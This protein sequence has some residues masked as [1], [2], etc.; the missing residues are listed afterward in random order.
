MNSR[1][2]I[3]YVSQFFILVGLVAGALLLSGFAAIIVWQAMVGGDIMSIEKG[4]LDPANAD[5]VKMVQLVSSAIM[6]LLPAFVFAL[7]VNKRPAKHL[8]LRTKFNWAQV[9]LITVMVFVAFGLSGALGELTTEIPIAEKWEKKFKAWEKLYVDQVM[10]MANMKNIG[11]YLYTL[12]VIAVAPAIF[13][14]LLFRGALQQLMVKWTRVAWLGILITSLLFSAVH[15][16]YYG[17]FART[18]LGMVL[19]YMFYFSKSLWLPIIAHFINNGFAVTAMYYMN[20]Q[21]KLSTHALDEKFPIWYGVIALAIIIV[22]F[23]FYRN[24]GKKLGTF[25]LDN[26]DTKNNNPFEG[27]PFDFEQRRS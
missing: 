24:E 23:I 16:S 5:A 8:G 6:F 7:V 18:A 2:S 14:E 12:L 27:E 4:M 9:G 25:Y 1:P 19:G 21:G 11:E 10:I 22:L 26:T 15:F 13:E 17:F 3:S 20:K